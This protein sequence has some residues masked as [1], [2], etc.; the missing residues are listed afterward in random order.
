MIMVQCALKGQNI[1]AQGEAL[2]TVKNKKPALK[3][4]YNLFYI[5]TPFQG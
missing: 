2:G 5:T 4:R 1:K 3:G